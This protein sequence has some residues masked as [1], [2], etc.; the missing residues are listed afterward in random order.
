MHGER[1]GVCKDGIEIIVINIFTEYL[2]NTVAYIPLSTLPSYNLSWERGVVS[3]GK[4]TELK[5]ERKYN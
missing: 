1:V 2:L 4:M 5:T 3:S